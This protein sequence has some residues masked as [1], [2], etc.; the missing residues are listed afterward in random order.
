M[1]RDRIIRKAGIILI[2][3]LLAPGMVSAGGQD[4]L[5]GFVRVSGPSPT[6]APVVWSGRFSGYTNYW[7]NIAW[8]WAQHGNLFLIGQPDVGQA[9]AQNKADIAEELGIPGLV[10]D[11]GFLAAWL[12]SRPAEIEDA[13]DGAL[14]AALGRGDVLVWAAPSSPLGAKLLSKAPDLAGARAALGSYQAR[15]AGY[16]ELIA[17]VLANG[18]RRLFAVVSGNAAD[19]RGFQ[20]LLAGV[21]DVVGRYDLH[22]GWFG[23]GTLLHSVT[24]HPGPSSRGHRAGALPGE[25]LV[26]LQR[27]HGLYDA[28]AAAG[29]AQEGRSR[30]RRRRRHGQGQSQPGNRRLRAAELRRPQD[31]GHAD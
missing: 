11:E 20:G 3:T 2:I 26:H 29:L 12:R 14:E 22:R 4:R 19:R 8:Q 28:E 18:D 16:R 17:F 30:H 27:L 25:R 21:R 6:A 9:I 7:Q 31:P 23:T 10:V 1:S 15:A 24:C 13:A 5:A